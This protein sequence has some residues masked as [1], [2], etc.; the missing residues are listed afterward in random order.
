MVKL[1]VDDATVQDLLQSVGALV[2]AET[3]W[4]LS[5]ADLRCKVVSRSRGYE[6]LI[7]NRIRD[8][9]INIEDDFPRDPFTR[10]FEYL[11]ENS[12][13]AAYLPGSGCIYL[14][15]ENVD[16]SNLE[17]LKLV[18]A[19]ELVHRA[20]H[21]RFPDL[22]HALDLH[23]LAMVKPLLEPG[24]TDPA[25]PNFEDIHRRLAE[26]EPVMTLIESHAFYIQE[27]IRTRYYPD[28]RIE[29]HR[30]LLTIILE[31]LNGSGE[32]RYTRGLPAIEQAYA[33]GDIEALFRQPERVWDSF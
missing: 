7:F 22:M 19:H 5:L 6:E 30:T 11:V 3:G 13:M 17:G 12:Y 21:L 15:R 31:W 8:L 33:G 25:V 23:L 16:D 4:E 27:R 18:L 20:Q 29:H 28:A 26:V 14:I 32:N 24:N 10:L 1:N 9:G 2:E